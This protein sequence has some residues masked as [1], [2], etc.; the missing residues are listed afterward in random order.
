MQDLFLANDSL[1]DTLKSKGRSGIYM[2][3]LTEWSPAVF[4]EPDKRQKHGKHQTVVK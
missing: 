1:A 2:E 3:D 4:V